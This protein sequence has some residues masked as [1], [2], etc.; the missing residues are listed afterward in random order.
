MVIKHHTLL[1]FVLF[2]ETN[3]FNNINYFLQ[4]SDDCIFQ[5][6]FIKTYWWLFNIK[7]KIIV[8]STQKILAP[9]L[10]H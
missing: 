8:L 2:H 7:G 9:N 1:N 5:S 6:V 4:S 10:Q 3:T